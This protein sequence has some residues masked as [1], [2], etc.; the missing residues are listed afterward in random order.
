MH[1]ATEFMVYL[2]AF[3]DVL[4][5]QSSALEIAVGTLV[6]GRRLAE[7]ERMIG[8]LVNPLIL[9]IP[10]PETPNSISWLAVVRDTVLDAFE[11][12]DVSFPI[13]QTELDDLAMPTLAFRILFNMPPLLYPSVRLVGTRTTRLLAEVHSVLPLDLSLAVVPHDKGVYISARYNCEVIPPDQIK[14]LITQFCYALQSRGELG[15][16]AEGGI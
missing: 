4:H 13:V 16:R 1:G 10:V 14:S 8:L 3:V 11:H 12:Q 2:S 6:S 15:R 7:F 5:A 9:R